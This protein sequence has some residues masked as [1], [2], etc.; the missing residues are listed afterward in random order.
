MHHFATDVRTL[1][2]FSLRTLVSRTTERDLRTFTRVSIRKH[3]V[4]RY[5][6]DTVL[7][8]MICS[9]MFRVAWN[10]GCG[11]AQS[12]GQLIAFRFLAGLGGSAP[13]AVRLPTE[14]SS[15]LSK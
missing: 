10:L 5:V 6:I 1:P 15:M 13:L 14:I 4:Y 8:G 3:V 12:S 9:S 7:S 11:F 2:T